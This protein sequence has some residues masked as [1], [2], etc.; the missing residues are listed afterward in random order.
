MGSATASNL[1]PR[2]MLPRLCRPGNTVSEA[3]SRYLRRLGSYRYFHLGASRWRARGN[4][5]HLRAGTQYDHAVTRARL[6][7]SPRQPRHLCRC[8]RRRLLRLPGLPSG[9]HRRLRSH[10]QPGDKGRRRRCKADDTRTPD[11]PV[12]G[13]DRPPGTD[14]GIDYGTTVSCYQ[15]DSEGRACGVCDSCRLRREGFTAAG[16]PDPT[17]YAPTRA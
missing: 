5:R 14:L 1:T 3:R 7:R 2:R 15:A 16:L 17:R 10:V 8:K 6:G 9:V 12:Q 4:P 13:R 11:R